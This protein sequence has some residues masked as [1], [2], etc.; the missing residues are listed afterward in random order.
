MG[1]F[2]SDF[3]SMYPLRQIL[4]LTTLAIAYQDYTTLSRLF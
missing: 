3:K 4:M 2:L 1:Y